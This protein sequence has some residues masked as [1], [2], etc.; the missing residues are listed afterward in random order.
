MY[1]NKKYFRVLALLLVITGIIMLVCCVSTNDSSIA[2]K[3]YYAK[4]QT[5]KAT[6]KIAVDYPISG[7]SKSLAN[8][9]AQ[10]ISVLENCSTEKYDPQKPKTLITQTAQNKYYQITH[11][12]NTSKVAP[13]YRSEYLESITKHAESENFITFAHQIY[14]YE[15][16]AHGLTM[17]EMLTYRKSDGKRINSSILRANLPSEF[18]KLLAQGIRAYFSSFG[19]DLSIFSEFDINDMPLPE[20]N[21]FLTNDGIGFVYSQYEIAPYASGEPAFIIPYQLIFPYLTEETANLIIQNDSISK[22]TPFS[23][24]NPWQK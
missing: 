12:D 9:Q 24:E 21:P 6:V 1:Y 20:N 23:P 7:S 16:G 11:T 10:I 3:R 17:T 2:T 14:T 18:K 22:I 15:G 13:T 5:P 4:E 8:I 19:E